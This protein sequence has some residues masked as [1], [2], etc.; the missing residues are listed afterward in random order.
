[1]TYF[2]T[3]LPWRSQC[4]MSKCMHSAQNSLLFEQNHRETASCTSASVWHLWPRS[5]FFRRPKRW[6]SLSAKTSIT[7][8]V[9]AL[10]QKFRWVCP[11]H[12]PYRPDLAPRDLN[13]FSSLIKYLGGH[14]CQNDVELQEVS[15]WFCF[16]SS[17]S[18]LKYERSWHPC[19][20]M[21][22]AFCLLII[23]KRVKQ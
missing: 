2:S 18:V 5:C 20:G 21:L 15:Q 7:W 1:M 11:K 12:P 16:Q 6:E 9:A 4:V 17:E 8:Q 23:L 19:F 22:K 3:Y 14:G 13:L 10:S